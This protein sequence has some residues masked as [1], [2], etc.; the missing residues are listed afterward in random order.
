VYDMIEALSLPLSLAMS[1]SATSR[2]MHRIGT[3]PGGN[4]QTRVIGT[5]IAAEGQGAM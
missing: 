5:W 2:R 4:T 1:F 3:R